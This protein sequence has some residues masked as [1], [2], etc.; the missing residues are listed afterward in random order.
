MFNFESARNVNINCE[1]NNEEILNIF[2]NIIF[3]NK[4]NEI[5]NLYNKFISN[6]N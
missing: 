1:N 3:Y 2:F 6:Y 4:Y 5:T